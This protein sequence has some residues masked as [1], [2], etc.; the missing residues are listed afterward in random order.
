MPVALRWKNVPTAA[1]YFSVNNPDIV[2]IHSDGASRNNPGH[3]A[4]GVVIADVKGQV[5][6]TISRYIGITTNNQ[7][8]YLALIAGLEAASMMGAD[9]VRVKVDSELVVKQLKGQYRVKNA[10]L[11][12]LY[13]KAADLLSGFKKYSLVHVLRAQNREADRLANLALDKRIV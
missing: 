6:E 3:A 8:E 12:P 1:G 2:I 5:L 11:R 9:E 4:I 13:L 7:A 10:D